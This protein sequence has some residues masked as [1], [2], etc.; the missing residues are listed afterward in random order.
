MTTL[1][2]AIIAATITCLAGAGVYEAQQVVLLQSQVASLQQQTPLLAQVRKIQSERDE[3]TKQI[4]AFTHELAVAQQ[5]RLELSALREEVNSLHQQTNRLGRL[6]QTL[7][8]QSG[9][10]TDAGLGHQAKDHQAVEVARRKN[11]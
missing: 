6:V 7:S 9:A 4:A 8:E 1:Q 10:T 3:A 5:D 2:K 11:E